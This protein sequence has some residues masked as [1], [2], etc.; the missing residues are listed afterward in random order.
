MAGMTCCLV[1][2]IYILLSARR[3]RTGRRVTQQGFAVSVT[4]DSDA[5]LRVVHALIVRRRTRTW[6]R[7]GNVLSVLTNSRDQRTSRMAEALRATSEILLL[8]STQPSVPTESC[9]SVRTP[10]QQH[11]GS[12]GLPFPSP[13]LISLSL[14]ASDREQFVGKRPEQRPYLVHR[15]HC[16]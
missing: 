8:C 5:R 13:C 10:Q 14:A 2:Q 1:I 11:V 4:P 3:R 12:A 7:L 9:S 6:A 16:S 15:H